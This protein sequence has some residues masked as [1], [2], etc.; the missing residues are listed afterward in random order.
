[1]GPGQFRRT[2]GPPFDIFQIGNLLTAAASAAFPPPQRE[3]RP[4]SFTESCMS[5]EELTEMKWP[6]LFACHEDAPHDTRPP[7]IYR[8]VFVTPRASASK[9]NILMYLYCVECIS[10]FLRREEKRMINP[11]RDNGRRD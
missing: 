9:N 7:C 6:P 4:P 1:M 11:R 2:M 8:R 3:R 10:F 5:N